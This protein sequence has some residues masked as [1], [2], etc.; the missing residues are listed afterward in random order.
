MPKGTKPAPPQQSTLGEMWGK[1]KKREPDAN[2]AQEDKM[3]ID[4]AGA[5]VCDS[6][7]TCF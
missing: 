4:K 5:R 6:K 3:D 2:L 1:K 7:L